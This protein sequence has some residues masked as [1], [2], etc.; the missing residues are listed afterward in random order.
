MCLQQAEL[1][2]GAHPLGKNTRGPSLGHRLPEA[3]Q[4]PRHQAR[5]QHVPLGSSPPIAPG[6]STRLDTQQDVPP[7][8]AGLDPRRRMIPITK[9]ILK[10]NSARGWAYPHDVSE[11]EAMGESLYRARTHPTDVGLAQRLALWAQQRDRQ[12]NRTAE[13]GLRSQSRT[14]DEWWQP[15]SGWEGQHTAMPSPHL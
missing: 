9:I 6:T 7:F 8:K 11:V 2:V 4:G 13:Q 15:G 10:V 5:A 1:R 3:S 12:A 14:P